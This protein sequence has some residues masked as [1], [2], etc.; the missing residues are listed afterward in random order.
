MVGHPAD[1]RKW[2]ELE[3]MGSRQLAA[4]ASLVLAVLFL[5]PPRCAYA[6][7]CGGASI[8]RQLSSS[9]AV[10]SGEVVEIE[11][12]YQRYPPASRGYRDTVTLRVSEALKG[13]QRETSEVKT[14][15]SGAAC[16]YPFDE[17]QEYLVFADEGKQGLQVHSCGGTQRLAEAQGYLEVLGAGKEPTGGGALPNTSGVVS[18]PAIAGLGLAASV[19]AV[20]RLVRVGQK[21]GR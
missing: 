5:L 16:G 20:A 8:Q 11:K 18:V 15:S 3:S 19:L 6:C 4:L 7:S 2:K 14:P 12:R 10:F 1:R 13:P 21:R 9:D 17:G